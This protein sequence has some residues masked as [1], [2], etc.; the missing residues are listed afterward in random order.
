[1]REYEYHQLDVFTSV[2]Y[3]GNPVAIVPDAGE[4]T[5]VE[6][7]QISREMS[8]PETA[9][10][11]LPETDTALFRMRSFTP[12]VE[13]PFTGH[14]AI[15]VLWLMTRLGRVE[16]KEPVT[17]V[18]FEQGIGSQ[19]ANIHVS[20]G[21]VDHIMMDQ[22]PPDFITDL[23]DMQN[24]ARG[25][26]IDPE[27]I[28]GTG[29]P[30]QV[31]STGIPQLIVPVQS[32]SAVKRI[33]PSELDLAALNRA[34]N[35]LGINFVLVFTSET[36][37]TETDFHARGFGHLLGIPEDPATGTANGALGAYLV[38]NGVLPA[39]EPTVRFTVEQGIEMGRPGYIMVEVDQENGEPIATR[40]GGQVVQVLKGVI[41]F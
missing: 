41:Q 8:L 17:T 4:L 7:R 38:K 34:L 24:L 1:M 27:E 39:S 28:T 13:L 10:L 29:L 19:N 25:L 32:L 31:V 36:E 15:G 30:V 3:R 35:Y 26:G 6:M 5:T 40:I 20:D 9:F 16:L 33:E 14:P 22:R 18:L 2:P 23:D 12:A 21:Q 11:V 37:S